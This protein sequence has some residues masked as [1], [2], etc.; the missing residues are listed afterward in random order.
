MASFS[1]AEQDQRLLEQTL[2]LFQ[3]LGVDSP[4][5]ET[6][7]TVEKKESG[8]ELDAILG[9]GLDSLEQEEVAGGVAGD[10][11]GS[12]ETTL[13][14]HEVDPV[15]AELQKAL[16]GDNQQVQM[17]QMMTQMEQVQTAMQEMMSTAT[18]E[19]MQEAM[20]SAEAQRFQATLLEQI[21]S[22]M[23][24]EIPPE[25]IQH[26]IAELTRLE[27]PQAII[28]KAKVDPK[29]LQVLAGIQMNMGSVLPDIQLK[30]TQ[31]Q[32]KQPPE[33]VKTP[34]DFQKWMQSQL[35][36]AEV[37]AMDKYQRDA[38]IAHYSET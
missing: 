28:E 10:S 32:F 13:I 16:Q 38:I 34:E 14:K 24:A 31:L 26:M 9:A 22:Q 25:E 11:A 3:Q 18:P 17:E 29:L 36:P 37:Q 4:P 15:L 1:K 23:P 12:S 6:T 19:M 21:F 20:R 27:V 30:M 7:P 35:D 33:S 5:A 2:A 8:D